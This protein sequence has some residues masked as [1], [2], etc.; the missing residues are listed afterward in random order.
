[1][2]V[3]KGSWA[4]TRQIMIIIWTIALQQLILVRHQKIN[5]YSNIKILELN[6][7]T[8][9]PVS[10]DEIEL[11]LGKCNI[12]LPRTQLNCYQ[13]TPTFIITNRLGIAIIPKHVVLGHKYINFS[14]SARVV[15]CRYN[16]LSLLGRIVKISRILSTGIVTENNCGKVK[17]Q[18]RPGFIV[19][20]TRPM[21]L[22]E[23]LLH[24]G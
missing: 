9:K 23:K 22:W 4:M 7:N 11:W 8:G 20:F 17:A 6:G 10:N 14:S 18:P 21:T 5:K 1:M 16:G 24:P 12:R 3:L 2:L 19:Y 15:D 13:V